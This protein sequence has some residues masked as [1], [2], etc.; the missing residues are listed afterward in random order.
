MWCIYVAKHV[1]NTAHLQSLNSPVPVL[2]LS[3]NCL[4]G[5]AQTVKIGGELV[6]FYRNKNEQCLF[7]GDTVLLASDQSWCVSMQDV[8]LLLSGSA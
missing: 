4:N 6:N 2:Q 3:H 5:F 1:V 7:S 8:R